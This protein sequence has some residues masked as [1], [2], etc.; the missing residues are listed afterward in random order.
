MGAGSRS[1]PSD[2]TR[3]AVFAYLKVYGLNQYARAFIEVG[4][5]DL[6][7]IG[8]LSETEALEFLERLRVY[9]GH[10]LRL[11]RAIDCLRHA[12]LGAE[13][14]D[15]A[16]ML[17]DDAALE[18]LCAQNEELSKVKHETEDENKRLQEENKR[19]LGVMQQQ[20]AQ[21]QKSRDRIQ[22]LEEMVQAQT[23]Q[24]NFLAQQLQIVAEENP[25]RENALYRSY[26]DTFDDTHN[27]WGDAEKINLPEATALPEAGGDGAAERDLL[28]QLEVRVA[29]SSA[30]VGRG[31]KAA[32]AGMVVP[33]PG[34]MTE[35]P[36]AVRPKDPFSPPR[37][38]KMAQSLDSAQIRECLAGFD[39]D[40]IIR[41]LATAIQN[42]IIMS[43]SKPRP[44][45]ASAA[46]LAACAIFLEPAC[47]ERL[48]R[49]GQ[50]AVAA[51]AVRLPGS[52][53]PGS[54]AASP[55][56]SLCSPL[57]SRASASMELKDSMGK[58]VDP[59]NNIA[60]RS[61]PNKWDIYG[62]LRDVMVNFRLEPEVSVITLFYLERFSELSGVAVTPDNW[63]RLTIA[64]M[65]LA[66]K[67]WNDES[68]ENA[69]FAQ[70]CPL[71]T[72][73]EINTFERTFLKSVGYNMS[74]KGSEYA[75]TYF[76]LRTL[77]AKDAAD[78]G[79]EPMNELRASRLAE[80]CLEKQ[81]EFRERYPDDAGPSVMNWTL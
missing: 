7:S 29:P 50:Q 46:C 24:V 70:L 62:F 25:A 53:G 64:S 78:F 57:M 21:L 48:E 54:E 74:V 40:H 65:M 42:K 80:R 2:V 12:A 60:V 3:T 9:P 52:G 72:L 5:A 22:E 61:V 44:H 30:P 41:C 6:E 59:L 26:K 66:S 23:E 75:K 69:E 38:A 77:G 4:L 58:P 79:L 51:A 39:V 28:R 56:S 55:L 17:E 68:F 10:R 13:R 45:T 37:R 1:Q 14:R 47:R 11:L 34:E 63:Q 71:Y 32:R 73:E 35:S 19:L 67:V 76:L 36:K 31:S 15:A 20:N 81:I 33:P 49:A 43:V 27:D 16:Q 18:R 8:R